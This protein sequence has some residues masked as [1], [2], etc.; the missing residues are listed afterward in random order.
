[1]VEPS[2]CLLFLS[3]LLYSF[4]RPPICPIRYLTTPGLDN[5][6]CLE[7]S[8]HA[9]GETHYLI[10]TG[11][12]TLH[13]GLLHSVKVWQTPL[14][15]Y[16]KSQGFEQT[17]CCDYVRSD[18]VTVKDNVTSTTI[19]FM[20]I[21]AAARW[22]YVMMSLLTHPQLQASYFGFFSFFL[23]AKL[24]NIFLKSVIC[25]Q[26]S[27]CEDL[28]WRDNRGLA[29]SKTL[30][31]QTYCF[32]NR[33]ESL[34]V[35]YQCCRLFSLSV[36]ARNSSDGKQTHQHL[37]FWTLKLP[38][39]HS[40]LLFFSFIFLPTVHSFGSFWGPLAVVP[41]THPET[42]TPTPCSH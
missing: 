15:W 9:I 39:L 5:P 40:S 10:K 1:M 21:S 24:I 2:R 31:S 25:F 3:L 6:A 35:I 22:V 33:V 18:Q 37:A 17:P 14:K 23:W 42:P 20:F 27:T 28:I 38:S 29:I 34:Y 13:K 19:L 30:P 11:I 8:L 41:I 4:L 32:E 26:D 12:Q 7:L 16:S 36:I